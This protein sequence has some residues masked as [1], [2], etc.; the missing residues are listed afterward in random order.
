[1]TNQIEPFFL[2][3]NDGAKALGLGRSKFYELVADNKIRIVKLGRKSLV[4]VASLRDFADTL[5]KTAA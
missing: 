5:T 4:P 2:P 3:V 1:M